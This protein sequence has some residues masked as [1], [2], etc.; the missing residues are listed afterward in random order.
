[1]KFLPSLASIALLG[2]ASCGAGE[3][4][5]P[6]PENLL[7][8][9]VDTLRTDFLGCYGE[10]PSPTPN[11]DGLAASGVLFEHAVSHAS[12]TLPSFA[13][14]FTSLYTSSHKCWNFERRLDESFVTLPE[15]FQ[16]A[17][18]DT[19]GMA[20]HIFFD[21]KYGL[22]QG[23]DTFDDEFAHRRE[24]QGWVPVTS[25]QL[26]A[27][28][29]SWLDERGGKETPWLLLLHY[30]D[31]HFPYVPHERALVGQEEVLRYK[32]EIGFTDDHLGT[33]LDALERN[34]FGENTAVLFIS[35]HG[36]AFEEH[37]GVKRH[38]KSLHREELRVP[39]L[40]RIPGVEPRRVSEL[41]RTV[42][43][44]PTLLEVFRIEP[45][46][47]LPMEGVSLVPAMVGESYEPGPL[48]SEIRLHDGHHADGLIEGRWKLIVDVSTG[49]E[50]LYDLEADVE[51]RT[52]L[53]DE[54]P[55]VVARLRRRL[56]EIRVRAE[57]WG[58]GFEDGGVVDLDEEELEHMKHMGYAGED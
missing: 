16:S 15:I 4:R 25:P 17:G 12:W 2:L 44:L 21:D 46:T 14:I 38:A 10:E 18:F 23:F 36:E 3:P 43:V 5:V 24:D 7:V 58:R 9:C 1:M 53:A 26:S 33:V 39:M 50:H 42:D 6:Q 11:I 47:P 13:A 8:I 37:P 54:H 30:F 49:A 32:G 57:A 27:K 40:L 41:V 31:P 35:D 52:N 55:E 48:L 56:A 28:A 45:E 51:E 20:T 34:G 19:A 22:Q 29:V